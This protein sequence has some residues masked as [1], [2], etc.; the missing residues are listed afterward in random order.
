MPKSE[1]KELLKFMKPYSK[2]VQEIALGLREFVWDIYP[3]TNELIYDNY[4]T[5]AFGWSLTDK[6]G[7]TFCSIALSS[8]DY[9][10]FGFFRGAD[11]PDPDK[12][13]LGKGN[14]YRYI[15]VSDLKEFPK[16]KIKKLLKFAH[17]NAVVRMKE[18]NEKVNMKGKT[19]V[20]SISPVKK[21]PK[22]K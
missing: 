8:K 14:Q 21:R 4:N 1:V 2:D 10:H 6:L 20:K 5:V 15:K 17:T 16:A 12:I 7:D 9:C 18:R 11:L 13:L 19:I 3:N 22:S